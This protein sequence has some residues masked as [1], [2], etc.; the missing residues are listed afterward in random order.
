MERLPHWSSAIL[1][2]SAWWV[3]HDEDLAKY[4]DILLGVSCSILYCV[5]GCPASSW[6]P[7]LLVGESFSLPCSD[8]YRGFN[9]RA[10]VTWTCNGDLSLIF[11]IWNCTFGERVTIS[12]LGFDEHVI[13]LEGLNETLAQLQSQVSFKNT[14]SVVS[15][16]F[17]YKYWHLAAMICIMSHLYIVDVASFCAIHA[18]VISSSM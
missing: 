5:L 17:S 8:V 2:D 15:W 18:R 10:N 16:A 3:F 13:S 1:S 14:Y 11:G 6:T 9:P 7:P 4:S 12:E